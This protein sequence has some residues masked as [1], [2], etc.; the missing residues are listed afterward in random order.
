MITGMLATSARPKD[1][2]PHAG[3]A[4][5]AST[6]SG[7]AQFLALEAPLGASAS[8]SSV[9]ET[10]PGGRLATAS[11]VRQAWTVARTVLLVCVDLLAADA[12]AAV[13]LHTR[14]SAAT[15][16]RDVSSIDQTV[17]LTYPQLST[18]LMLVWVVTLAFVGAHHKRRFTSLWDQGAAILRGGVGLLA[19]LGITSLFTRLQLSRSYVGVAMVGL[20]CFTFLGRVL[21]FSLFHLLL[22]IGIQAD[23]VLLIG[24]ADQVQEIRRHLERTSR[25][26]RVIAEVHTGA[27]IDEPGTVHDLATRRGITS[28]IVCGP[29]T[30]PT[31]GLR[32][33]SALLRGSGVSVVVAPG[34]AEA[35]APAVQMHPIGD[36]V[37]LRVR[38]SEQRAVD[39][40]AKALIDRVGGCL[41]LLMATPLLVIVAVLVAMEGRPV[42]F[43]QRR[44]G[45]RGRLFT[46]YKFRTMAPDAEARLH[47]DG[48]Y[49]RYVANGFKLPAD[50]DPRITTIGRF[51]RRTSLDELPQLL[52]VARG[53]MSLVGPRPVVEKEL[54]SYGDLVSTYTGVKPGVTGYWQ[55]NGRSDIGF[56]ERAELDAYYF[57]HRSVRFDLRILARTV[58]TVI[59]RRGAH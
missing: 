19:L 34:T 58:V 18:I 8:A 51:L 17:R 11:Q 29:T 25:R 10:R 50:E 12:A 15:L 28:V 24:P 26:V 49:E 5:D 55:I 13:A 45:R 32:R 2:D 38:D 43:R 31:G 56:P 46:I 57:D 37:L 14:L 39:R 35:L 16:P 36:L 21:L 27:P 1:T 41:A 9:T 4:T 44:V 53:Q 7:W 42:L 54:A 59:L 23:R 47:R 30:L 3:A 33:L 22:R 52:N 48:L 6:E 20:L 40:A